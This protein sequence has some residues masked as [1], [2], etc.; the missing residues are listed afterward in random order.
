[1]NGLNAPDLVSPIEGC[2]C[3]ATEVVQIH[4]QRCIQVLIQD[5]DTEKK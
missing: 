1:M 5:V 4:P 2:W 3:S